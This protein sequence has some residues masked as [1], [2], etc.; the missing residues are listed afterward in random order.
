MLQVTKDKFKNLPVGLVK[1]KKAF[2]MNLEIICEEN[3]FS[4]NFSGNA[5]MCIHF[6]E[7]LETFY[8]SNS[9]LYPV[10]QLLQL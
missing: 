8:Q 9:Y 1:T 10:I 6:G 4:D 2:Y 7:F 5:K 3:M